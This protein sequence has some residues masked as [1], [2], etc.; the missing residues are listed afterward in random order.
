MKAIF[1][2]NF[3]YERGYLLVYFI[4]FV[5]TFFAQFTFGYENIEIINFVPIYFIAT[6]SI[7]CINNAIL[8]N[9]QSSQIFYNSLPIS[10]IDIVKAHYLYNLLLT[11]ISFVLIIIIALYKN[12]TIFLQA[13]IF[14]V[15]TNLLTLSI[16]YPT[17][18]HVNI[19]QLGAWI[20][21]AM[22]AIFAMLYFGTYSN[23]SYAFSEILGWK[24]F[25]YYTPSM[26]LIVAII[27]WIIQF[28]RAIH[29]AKKDKI[30]IYGG[31]K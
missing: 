21:G 31:V 4:G 8:L 13:A 18:A 3:M 10:K 14:I 19:N 5:L 24:I 29:S 28:S 23:R 20:L 27:I 7:H 15:A 12:D 6:V 11:I 16:V 26:L 30:T 2:R 22:Y 9:K 17:Y 25:L 1:Y